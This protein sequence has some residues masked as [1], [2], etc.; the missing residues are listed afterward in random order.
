MRLS[1][2]YNQ[3]MNKMLEQ[4][5]TVAATL[6]D[7]DQGKLAEVVLEE[8]KRLAVLEGIADVEAG[9]TVPHSEIKTWLESWGTDHEMPAPSCK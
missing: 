2:Y 4:A 3:S 5:M 9:R 6:T 1:V 7:E 8:A